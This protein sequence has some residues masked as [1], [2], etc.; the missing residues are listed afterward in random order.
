MRGI[1]DILHNS[2]SPFRF[3][4]VGAPNAGVTGKRTIRFFFE[5]PDEESNRYFTNL[6]TASLDIEVHEEAPPKLDFERCAELELARHYAHPLISPESSAEMTPLN[7]ICSALADGGAFEVI[8]CRDIG[9]KTSVHQFVYDRIHGKPS[10]SKAVADAAFDIYAEASIQRDIKDVSRE[11]WWSYR[12]YRDDKWVQKEVADAEKKLHENLFTCEVRLYGDRAQIENMKQAL[13]SRMNRFKVFRTRRNAFFPRP[14]KKPRRIML[15]NVFH[16]LWWIAPIGLVGAACYFGILDLFRLG[17]FDLALLTGSALLA[18]VMAFILRRKNP[19]VLS[20]TELSTIIGLPSNTRRLPVRFGTPGFSMKP[21]PGRGTSTGTA[22]T[23][24]S[25]EEE[26]E[27][28]IPAV[29]IEEL[30]NE[31]AEETVKEE[32]LEENGVEEEEPEE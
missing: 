18:A 30:A 14:L 20:V 19:I 25:E 26:E 16:P 3:V 8:A 12:R 31:E 7:G 17:T 23:E 28:F 11:A 10:F 29:R 13:P 9:A 22:V 32:G 2:G 5:F 4:A 15:R 21:L 24:H 6:F 1:L 27:T